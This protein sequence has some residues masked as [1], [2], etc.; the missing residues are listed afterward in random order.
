MEIDSKRVLV[1]GGAGFIGSNLVDALLE[2]GAFVRAIDD[3]SVGHERNLIHARELGAEIVR[4]DITDS[5]ATRLALRGID[6]VMHLACSCLRVSLGRPRLSHEINAGGTLNVLEAAAEVGL[7]RF[8]YCSSSEVYG[9]AKTELMAESHPTEPTT[10]YGASKLAG[11]WYT[12]AY[13]NTH[14]LPAV[15][16]RPFNTYGYREHVGGPSAEVI[17]KMTLRALCGQPP[18]IF[19]DGTQSRDFTF[20]TDTV[21]GIIAATESDAMVGQRVNI[22]FGLEVTIGRIG[23]LVCAACS[24]G[25][26]PVHTRPRP[27]DVQRHAADVSKARE[28]LGFAPEVAI[29]EGISRFVSWFSEQFGNE[30]GALLAADSER[31]WSLAASP[32]A[33]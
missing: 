15:V 17:P 23:E 21:R 14:S 11:E 5:E 20:V 22:A 3:F 4:A 9:S 30:L 16:V 29:E 1:T 24:S 18:V 31:N 27:A 33:L 8:V 13:S 6:V 7:E 2:R 28:L 26:S 25:V 19:G 12:L 10:V 32:E